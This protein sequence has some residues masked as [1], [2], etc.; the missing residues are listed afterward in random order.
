MGLQYTLTERHSFDGGAAGGAAAG[1]T[2][3]SVPGAPAG[4][5]DA[6]SGGE[7]PWH[8]LTLTINF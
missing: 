7:Q 6:A 8:R 4:G 1:S 5:G 3:A 2:P